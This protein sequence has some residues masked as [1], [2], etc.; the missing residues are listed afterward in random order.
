MATEN[1]AIRGRKRALPHGATRRLQ[2]AF[3]TTSIQL[4]ERLAAKTGEPTLAGVVRDALK[5]YTWVLT[6]QEQGR[7]IVSE[8]QSGQ[9]RRELA[10]L[11]HTEYGENGK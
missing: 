8:D 7:C 4:L 10:P 3:P 11:L 6:E 1:Q 2:F 5:I 9:R